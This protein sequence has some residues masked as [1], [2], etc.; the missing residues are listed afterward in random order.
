MTKCP[1]C[2]Q[3]MIKDWY[4]GRA[5]DI[6]EDCEIQIRDPWMDREVDNEC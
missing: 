2:G 3:P 5:Y 4:K 1:D 6:C